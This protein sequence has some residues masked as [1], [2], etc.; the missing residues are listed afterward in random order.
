MGDGNWNRRLHEMRELRFIRLWLAIGFM[1][2][3]MVCF[4]TLTPSP[5]DMGDFPESDKIGHFFAYSVMMLWFGFIYL[6]GKHYMGVGLAFIVMGI[7][8]ELI[9]GMLGYRSFSYLDMGANAC[10]VVL[11]W[12]LART[13]LADALVYVEGRLSNDFTL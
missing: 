3:G 11:G 8:L 12:L 4:L 5:P 7:V 10:G 1:L 13:R 2:V 9:Q 6:R